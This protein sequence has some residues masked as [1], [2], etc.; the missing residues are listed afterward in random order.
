MKYL[1][2]QELRRNWQ[3]AM[4]T[5]GTFGPAGN[6]IIIR[7]RNYEAELTDRGYTKNFG[8]WKKGV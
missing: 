7:I 5:L 8:E 6:N 4:N 1:T 3:E 2:D